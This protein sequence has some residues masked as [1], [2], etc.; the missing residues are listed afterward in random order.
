MTT[1]TQVATAKIPIPFSF[2]GLGDGLW[3]QS[4]AV[5]NAGYFDAMASGIIQVGSPAAGQ[6]IVIWAYSDVDDSGFYTGGAS[7]LDSAYVAAGGETLFVRVQTI[8][9]VASPNFEYSWGV[10]GIASLFGSRGLP[11]KWGLAVHNSSGAALNAV[12]ANNG[13]WYQGLTGLGTA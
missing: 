12:G 5:V 10:Q 2:T 8:R 3:W 13:A 7:G 9:C 4:D 6:T 11:S 1:F